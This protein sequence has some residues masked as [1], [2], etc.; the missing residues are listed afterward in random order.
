MV[1]AG[2]TGVVPLTHS[3]MEGAATRAGVGGEK[4]ERREG[5]GGG[6]K[7]GDG[8]ARPGRVRGLEVR[9]GR[10]EGRPAGA[11]GDVKPAIHYLAIFIFVTSVEL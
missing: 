11:V 9:E 1:E 8:R 2:V 5:E 6:E 3:S 7:G 4:G 10:L